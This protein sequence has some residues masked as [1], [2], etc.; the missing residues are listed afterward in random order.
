MLPASRY[1]LAMHEFARRHLLAEVAL[2]LLPAVALE[3]QQ[4]VPQL[5]A[6]Q[7][8]EGVCRATA[9]RCEEPAFASAV[10]ALVDGLRRLGAANFRV[11]APEDRAAVF[12]VRRVELA[13]D[14][15]YEID[16]GVGALSVMASSPR[17]VARAAAT[18]LQL[19]TIDADG[20]AWPVGHIADHP[21]LSFRCFMVD[22]GRN[23]HSPKVLRQIVDAC[24]FYKVGY[25]Q[26]HLSDDQLFSWPSRAFPKLLDQRSG[27]T[28]QAFV[29]LEA[30]SQA[31]G[32]TIIPEL[33][34]PGHSTILRQR[35]PE[36]FGKEPTDL[37]T[38]PS[39]LQG[40]EALLDELMLVFAASPF[41]HVGG[42]EAYGVPGDAQRDFLNRLHRYLKS[43]GR[44]AIAWEGPRLGEGE[45]K[46]DTGVLHM[47]WN[48]V[49]FPAQQMLDAG[50]EVV[51]AAW[52][53][54]YIVD[55]YPRTMFTAV[56][57]QRCYEWDLRRFA[58]VDHGMPTFAKPHVTNTSKG[59][60]GFCM[61]WWEGREQ[62]VM[63]LCVPRL[64]AVSSAAWNR[65]GEQDFA[66]FE[67]RQRVSLPRL[68]ML[69]GASMSRLPVADA[70]TQ[71]G[72]LA[73]GAKVSPST[74]ASQPVFG[75]QR[76]T[77]GLVDRFDHFLG[78]PTQPEPLEIVV[79]LGAAHVVGRVVVH[80]TAVAGSHEIY[81]LL[82]SVDGKHFEQ[83]GAASK[84]SRGERADVA[85]VFEARRVRFVKVMTHGC[86][87]LTFPSFSRLC[88]VQVFAR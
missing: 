19:A 68:E 58:Q 54:M 20:V 2:L 81:E 82:V 72:N 74:G 77:N 4:V 8:R 39:A 16:V 47:N 32:V 61:P 60:V 10:A 59:I 35:Y 67:A 52:D 66:D 42:D 87:G 44:S 71:I 27:W 28:W 1:R 31:R 69:S 24:W 80:E 83:V 55:H 30:Y 62:N 18:L 88:E 48:T 9:V 36:V 76:L 51:N 63:A 50:Y 45:H 21:D 79:D 33:D 25:L 73:F 17:G 6:R 46:V 22:M 84:G 3:A 78:F 29:E 75:P 38:L 56:S 86:H 65:Q 64:A 23:P 41:V 85:H 14:E 49:D 12:S 37:A 43:K 53:P 15:A 70:S 26:L 57:V 5:H 13:S 11:A 34:V 7:F 40:V